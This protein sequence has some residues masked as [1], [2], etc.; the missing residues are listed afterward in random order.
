MTIDAGRDFTPADTRR[1]AVVLVNQMFTR[2]WPGQHALA[3]TSA[4][5]AAADG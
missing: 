2:I 1:A 4:R 5:A 3:A